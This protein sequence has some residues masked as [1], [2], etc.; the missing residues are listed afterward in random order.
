MKVFSINFWGFTRL[1]YFKKCTLIV[2]KLIVKTS[3]IDSYVLFRKRATVKFINSKICVTI[4]NSFTNIVLIPISVFKLTCL[5]NILANLAT[6]SITSGTFRFFGVFVSNF[7][8]YE[9]VLKDASFTPTNHGRLLPKNSFAF[10]I[11]RKM[12]LYRI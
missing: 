4:Y 1:R 3:Y 2:I 6:L 11:R 5:L 12:Y 8:S 10:L 9:I 7:C